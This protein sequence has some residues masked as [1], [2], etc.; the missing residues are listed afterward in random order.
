MPG[1]ILSLIWALLAIGLVLFL[2]YAFTRF[3]AGRGTL[4]KLR[5]RNRRITILEQVPVGRD[6][7]LLL[8]RL[9]ERFYFLGTAQGSV[10]CLREV[11]EDEAARWAQEDASGGPA[12]KN[13]SFQEA[14]RKVLEQRKR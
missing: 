13:M 7:K 3:A 2:A 6:Q 1:D 4:G 10:T 14:V 8:V 9:G 5:L 11:P 12:E